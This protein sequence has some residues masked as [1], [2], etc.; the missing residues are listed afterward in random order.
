MKQLGTE[1][2]AYGQRS[3]NL[4]PVLLL[5]LIAVC[6]IMRLMIAEEQ[7]YWITH[8]RFFY[9]SPVG[10]S[11]AEDSVVNFLKEQHAKLLPKQ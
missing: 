6:G 1:R 11:R 7:R 9:G 4:L 2:V 3:L 5:G 8:D 10:F